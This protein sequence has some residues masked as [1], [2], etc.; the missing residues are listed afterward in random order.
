MGGSS[1]QAPAG[2]DYGPIFAAQAEQSK[3]AMDFMDRQWGEI[4]R[5][6]RKNEPIQ[7][8]VVEMAVDRMERLDKWAI[9]DRKRYDSIYAPIED[10]FAKQASE[11]DSP[12]RR[13][14]EAGKAEANIA[15]QFE[16]SRQ[17]ALDRLEKYGV[18]PSQTRYGALDSQSRVAEA[19]AQAAA[20]NTAR[21]RI[22]MMGLQLK[23][24]AIQNGQSVVNRGLQED[25]L[26]GAAGQQAVGTGIAGVG[27]FAQTLGTPG[28]WFKS[29]AAQ[30]N[31][32]GDLMAKSDANNIDRWKAE[33]AAKKSSGFEDII[34]MVTGMGMK[35]FGGGFGGKAEHGGAIPDHFGMLAYD[36][37]GD[38][39]G[40]DGGIVPDELSPSGGAIPDDITAQVGDGGQA[41]INAGEF[42]IPKDVAAWLGQ[43]E[44][45]KLILKSRKEMGDP[46]A[47][48][49]QPEVG[50]A[51]GPDPMQLPAGLSPPP[52]A[53]PSPPMG[54]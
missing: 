46:N 41:Q 39:R 34:G 3:R 54:G 19:A 37:G 42:V 32:Q 47:A 30:T 4:T 10:A 6:Q 17:A 49:A 14:A 50:P 15:Q 31:A 13:E 48:P 5:M 2:P 12:V 38:V 25:Q 43:K 52:G 7:D 23:Q 51:P 18:D 16:Q 9:A 27:S 11:Y 8:H 36:D 1:P 44:M 21:D 33:Q 24:Q 20:G 35:A 22:E 40:G 28:D 53:I 45:Q 29:G 26:S